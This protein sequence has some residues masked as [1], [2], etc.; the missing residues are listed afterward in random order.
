MASSDFSPNFALR[1]LVGGHATPVLGDAG[2]PRR[3]NATH[4][5]ARGHLMSR[6]GRPVRTML[7]RVFADHAIVVTPDNRGFFRISAHVASSRGFS[8]QNDVFLDFAKQQP[9]ATTWLRIPPLCTRIEDSV[10][11]TTSILQFFPIKVPRVGFAVGSYYIIHVLQL[12][13]LKT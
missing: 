13:T 3:G 12:F 6:R 5:V 1:L 4:P 2:D 7:R 8:P 11:T 9:T 10:N